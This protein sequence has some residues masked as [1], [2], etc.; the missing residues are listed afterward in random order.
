MPFSTRV[1]PSDERRRG[2]ERALASA[3]DPALAFGQIAI[4][5]AGA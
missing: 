4:V 5:K 2:A 1:K 3:F